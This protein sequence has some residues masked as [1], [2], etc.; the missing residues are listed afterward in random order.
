MMKIQTMLIMWIYVCIKC[1]VYIS[2]TN[3]TLI[4]NS[5]SSSSSSTGSNENGDQGVTIP[6]ANTILDT[7]FAN[8]SGPVRIVIIT[9][10]SVILALILFCCVYC[11]YSCVQQ[12]RQNN[13]IRHL[14][15]QV[16]YAMVQQP[17]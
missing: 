7:I 13:T 2:G 4:N 6:D 16:D 12:Q 1:I 3:T 11:C 15:S 10:V 9:I 5:S 8:I 14:K 17:K